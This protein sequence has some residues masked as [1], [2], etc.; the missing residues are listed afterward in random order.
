[1]G[2]VYQRLR[3][4]ARGEKC[5]LLL[6][7]CKHDTETTVLAHLPSKIGLKGTGM[8]VPCWWACFACQNCHDILDRRYASADFHALC[9]EK[10]ILMAVQRTWARWFELGLL[11]V[12]GDEEKPPRKSKLSKIVPHP[13]VLRR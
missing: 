8:K 5:T 4:S 12:A 1:M 11:R 7:G 10:D 6:F 13:G 2:D 9:T 3:D